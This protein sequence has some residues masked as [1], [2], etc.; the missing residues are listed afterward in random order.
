MYICNE[1]FEIFSDH[2]IEKDPRPYGDTIVHEE[3]GV[4]PHC[5]SDDWS[6]AEQCTRCGEYFHEDELD[7]GLCDYCYGDLYG[8]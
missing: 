1:C 7:D 6:E 3:F 8:K 4:C 5:E 2:K